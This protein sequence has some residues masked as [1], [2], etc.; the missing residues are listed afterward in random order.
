VPAATPTAKASA[1]RASLLTAL[2]GIVVFAC[3]NANGREV[4]SYDSQAAKYTVYQL[5]AHRT[6][7]L[8]SI[9]AR[10]PAL[11]DRV[12]FATSTDGHTRL[13]T[14]V[15]PVLLAWLPSELL[16]ASGLVPLRP[17]NASIFA[18]A[19]ASLLVTLA[20]I[21]VFHAARRRTDDTWA[22][23]IALGFGLG[24]S[25][26]PTA[27]QTL[28]Q[29]ESVLAGLSLAVL[30][31]A[32]PAPQL[33]RSRLWLAAA[34][35]GIAG[36]ARPQV[37]AAVLVIA[38]SVL[39]R[40]RRA[41][42]AVTLLPVAAAA[43]ATL[44]VNLWWFGHPLGAMAAFEAQMHA[45]VHA[46][47]GSFSTS[48]WTGALGL[49]VSPSRGLLVFSPIVLL[50]AT[51]AGAARREGW[52]GDLRWCALAAAAQFGLYSAYSVWWGGHTYGPR[53]LTDL[54]PLLVPLVAAGSGVLRA[55]R[56]ARIVAA[57]A[58]AWSI[59]LAATGAFCYPAEAWNADPTDIDRD[60]QRLWDWTDP[61]FVRCW[62]TGLSPQNL[63]LWPPAG[64]AR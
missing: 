30:C 61:Q 1:G 62:R 3:Y 57:A 35:L 6:F 49:L 28:W 7:K 44:A 58:L 13:A 54:L 40:T 37:A 20:V 16:R 27:S 2:I 53:Y 46:V 63:S 47:S 59:A 31:L 51:G 42:A 29:H 39:A 8:D 25:A 15:M 55:R 36:A 9:V 64:A 22:A 21:F 52:A 56:P 48:P 23:L 38:V 18:K 60:H 33:S 12:V 41:S 24:T 19:A 45:E 5:V 14:P 50:A 26:W 11:R 17:P 34:G 32:P 10:Q 43:A 4:G